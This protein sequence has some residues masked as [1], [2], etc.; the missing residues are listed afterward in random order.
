MWDLNPGYQKMQEGERDVS[1]RSIH[2]ATKLS[3][4]WN[5]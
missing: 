5:F 3:S 4:F 1:A 2:Y